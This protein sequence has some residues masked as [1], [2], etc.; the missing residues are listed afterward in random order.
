M[1][2]LKETSIDNYFSIK[3][4]MIED[5]IKEDL[6]APLAAMMEHYEM[7]LE[8]N[9]HYLCDEELQDRY[10]CVVGEDL[11]TMEQIRELNKNEQEG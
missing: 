3:S 4:K 10:D 11:L 9:Y 8:D 2:R 1:K 7:L 6:D 5:I